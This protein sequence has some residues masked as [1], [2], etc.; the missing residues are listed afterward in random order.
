MIYRVSNNDD[1]SN[2]GVWNVMLKLNLSQIYQEFNVQ[3]NAITTHY[4][5]T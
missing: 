1:I 4:K 2:D 3:N 5:T